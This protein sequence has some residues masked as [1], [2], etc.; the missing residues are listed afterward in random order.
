MEMEAEELKRLVQMDEMSID[1]KAR[2]EGKGIVEQLKTVL[3]T[4]HPEMPS[5]RQEKY[6]KF[7]KESDKILTGDT[8]KLSNAQLSARKKLNTPQNK[9]SL[10]GLSEESLVAL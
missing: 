1:R 9:E 3:P 5:M 4:Y 10:K 8:N 6:N 2:Q 7:K